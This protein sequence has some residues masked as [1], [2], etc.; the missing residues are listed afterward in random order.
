[1]HINYSRPDILNYP[2][3]E[4]LSGT[5]RSHLLRHVD[6]LLLSS[7]NAELFYITKHQIMSGASSMMEPDTIYLSVY[8]TAQYAPLK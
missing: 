3:F 7:I 8:G 6:C 4:F 1:M 2:R 5:E